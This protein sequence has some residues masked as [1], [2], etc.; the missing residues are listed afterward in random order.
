EEGRARFATEYLVAFDA[1]AP[2]AYYGAVLAEADKA[3]RITT[4]PHD[5]SLKV[6]TAWDLGIDDATAIWFLQEAGREVRVIDYF[7]ASG[8]GLQAIVRQALADRP[9]VYGRHYLPHDVKVRELGANG[10]SR[11]ET[12]AGLGV[13]PVEVTAAAAPEDR[14]HALRQ[15]IPMAV[16]D[17]ARCATGLDRL[18][19]YRKRWNGA[20]HAWS[21]PLHDGASHAADALGLYALNRRAGSAVKRPARRREHQ[22]DWMA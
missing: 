20:L 8:E 13:S 12:L 17:A 19:A 11:L 22:L 9:F 18:R 3:G 15:M 16:F 6:D 10:R 7:E 2:G 1:P 21:G 14:I 5:P 4:V